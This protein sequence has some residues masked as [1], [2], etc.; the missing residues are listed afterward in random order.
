MSQ[1]RNHDV[2]RR[3][4]TDA[5]HINIAENWYRDVWL[6]LI[7]IVV[8]IA[9]WKALT[10][11]NNAN[12]LAHVIQ[13]QRVDSIRSQCETQNQHAS[14]AIARLKNVNG[15][16]A[17]QEGEIFI[18]IF[19]IAGVSVPKTNEAKL[20]TFLGKFAKS[21]TH[22]TVLLIDA[23]QPPQNCTLLVKKATGRN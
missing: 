15:Q 12:H 7:S 13:R 21:N 22:G 17:K 19:Q 8:G 3:R 23:I 4:S 14:N 2:P 5:L 9:V 10:A 20:I 6:L 18:K 11:S 1:S 16:S